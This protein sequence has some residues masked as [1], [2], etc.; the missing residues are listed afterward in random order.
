[1]DKDVAADSSFYICFASDLKRKDWLYKF[2][3]AYRF[4]LG[5]RIINEIPKSLSNDKNFMPKLNTCK[6]D[7]YELIKPLLG[8]DPKHMNDGEYEVIGIAYYLESKSSLRFLIIDDLRPR[9]FVKKHFPLLKKKLVGTIGF[10]GDCC[11]C[12]K[13]IDAEEAIGILISIKSA[14][15]E[16]KE[17]RPC[18]MDR[19]NY[20]KILITTIQKIMRCSRE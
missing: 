18:S 3:E 12:D 10:I 7:Y 9:N 8:R 16:G 13:K 5:E 15:E 19:E 14:V 2:L 17:R 6:Y 11:C 4:N 1:M 20:Q